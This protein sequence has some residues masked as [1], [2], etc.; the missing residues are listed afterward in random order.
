MSKAKDLASK[1]GFIQISPTGIIKG[2]SGTAS[3]TANGS[4]VFSG[5]ESIRL[6]GVFSSG[7]E[8]YRIIFNGVS[9]AAS[10]LYFNLY[11]GT[12]LANTGYTYYTTYQSTS[13]GPLRY[14][15]GNVSSGAFGIIN[16][17]SIAVSADI[18]GP[19]LAARTSMLTNYVSSGSSIDE[20]GM[21][22]VFH[23]VSSSYDGFQIGTGTTNTLTGTI[24][25][26]GYNNGGA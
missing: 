25:V 26:Y 1:T 19:A 10:S 23:A 20:T 4:V 9:T 2:A 3:V 14:T 6:S 12:T 17:L 21:Q 5:T 7:F 8:N 11:N 16:T 22:Q 24:R 13:S 15:L 18:F